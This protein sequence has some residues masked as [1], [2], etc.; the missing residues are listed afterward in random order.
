MSKVTKEDMAEALKRTLNDLGLIDLNDF[1]D[2]SSIV[3]G[4]DAEKVAESLTRFLNEVLSEGQKCVVF[5][6]E[7]DKDVQ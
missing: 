5:A 1:D 7:F 4:C 2:N 6:D 3:D